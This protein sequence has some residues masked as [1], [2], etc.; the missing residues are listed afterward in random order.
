M[1]GNS[2]LRSSSSNPCSSMGFLTN[3]AKSCVA[4]QSR[5]TTVPVMMTMG[6][7]ACGP[8]LRSLNQAPAV[9]HRHEQI[10]QDHVGPRAGGE[11]FERF[12]AVRH[13]A[14]ADKSGRRNGP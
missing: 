14:A 10:Q 5:V 8:L 4:A 2:T 13:Q 7:S 6:I 3:P 1:E 12:A 9:E 11:A